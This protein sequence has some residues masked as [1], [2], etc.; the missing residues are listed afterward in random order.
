MRHKEVF[1][2]RNESDSRENVSI[3][4]AFLQTVH[5]GLAQE[6]Q[7]QEGETVALDPDL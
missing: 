1:L 2:S 7:V 5:S 4:P 6:S 3:R